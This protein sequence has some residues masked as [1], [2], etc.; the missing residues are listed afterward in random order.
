MNKVRRAALEELGGKL[1]ELKSELENLRDEET[2]YYDNMPE[3][4]QNTER[5]ESSEVAE[6]LMSDALD[7]LASAI[8][9]LEE[10]A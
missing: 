2:E 10:I 9:N 6:S 5:G 8:G 1:G 3:N 4:L 7:N